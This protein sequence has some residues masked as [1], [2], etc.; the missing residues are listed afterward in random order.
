[1]T[2]LA[3]KQFLSRTWLW[4]KQNWEVVLAVAVTAGIGLLVGRTKGLDLGAVLRELQKKHTEEVD[5]IVEAQEA[6]V[7]ELVKIEK[8]TEQALKAIE[9]KYVEES[10]TLDRQKK[11]EIQKAVVESKGDPDAVTKRIAEL[12]G[13]TVVVRDD[14]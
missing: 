5:A 7:K 10:K 11:K 13:F 4:V 6:E 1:M 8:R 12:T 3:A 9:E 14:D 2:L